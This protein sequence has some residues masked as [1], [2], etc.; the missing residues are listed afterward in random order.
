MKYKKK[1]YSFEE[2]STFKKNLKDKI[3]SI[4]NI[5]ENNR[6]FSLNNLDNNLDLQ[7]AIIDINYN[8]HLDVRKWVYFKNTKMQ[9]HM[10]RPYLTLI[11]DI[12]KACNVQYINKQTSTIK[13]AETVYYMKYT[14]L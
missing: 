4:L 5:N 11:K 9:K 6:T 12:F 3:F 14:I 7:K 1:Q 13:N 10:I 8:L 2:I